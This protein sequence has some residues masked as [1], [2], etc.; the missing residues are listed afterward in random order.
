[1]FREE[2]GPAVGTF[3]LP[4]VSVLAVGLC[5]P[6]EHLLP[7]DDQGGQRRKEKPIPDADDDDGDGAHGRLLNAATAYAESPAV[8]N[9]TH[10]Q[11]A[12]RQRR[13]QISTT[14]LDQRKLDEE[15][16]P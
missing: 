7:P 14:F 11:R 16:K 1:M 5:D 6:R 12:R 15:Q 3:R 4:L 13:R 8:L 10:A 9:D 2:R